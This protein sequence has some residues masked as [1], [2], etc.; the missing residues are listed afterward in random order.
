[1]F[2]IVKGWRRSTGSSLLE[3]AG[4]LMRWTRDWVHKM[5][6][7]HS[8]GADLAFAAGHK[9]ASFS[10]GPLVLVSIPVWLCVGPGEP[11]YVWP[12]LQDEYRKESQ[13]SWVGP[14]GSWLRWRK[15]TLQG[16]DWYRPGVGD[17]TS[18]WR[19]KQIW[20]CKW[21]QPFAAY[22]SAGTALEADSS[23]LLAWANIPG[24]TTI[25]A[26]TLEAQDPF[27][28]W[29]CSRSSADSGASGFHGSGRD[30]R[31]RHC[32]KRS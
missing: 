19:Q 4:T 3:L 11:L 15:W 31:W 9:I 30:L 12:A 23:F 32:T 2:Q 14:S 6:W 17:Q 20:E 27:C 1:M 8:Q 13:T 16:R 21:G 5:F 18:K 7:R 25:S 24:S 26:G 10:F 22:A 29:P 28:H